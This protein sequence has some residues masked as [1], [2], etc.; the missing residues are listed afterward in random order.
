MS[1]G[2]GNGGPQFHGTWLG[3]RA[4]PLPGTPRTPQGRLFAP[5][6]K[7][8]GDPLKLHPSNWMQQPG[9]GEKSAHSDIITWHASDSTQLP[10]YDT[11]D[12][13]QIQPE[14]FEGPDWGNSEYDD[15]GEPNEDYT[16]FSVDDKDRPM[17]DYGSAIGMHF[18][19][20]RA[21]T[22]RAG[23]MGRTAFH[24]VRLP[25]ETVAPPPKGNFM[26]DRPGGSIAAGSMRS[27][28]RI[29][30]AETG[31]M[32]EDT[33]WSD[34]AANFA[35]KATDLVE[36][37]KSIA[38]RNDVE[39]KGTTSYRALPE[40]VRTWSEDVLGA[41]DPRSGMPATV[42][43]SRDEEHGFRNVPHPAL[44]HLAQAGYNPRQDTTDVTSHLG[45]EG[46]GSRSAAFDQGTLWSLKKP[47][48][49]DRW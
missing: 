48:E 40:T 5:V 38:Y 32:T 47:K 21:A 12:H 25:A 15:E 27:Q 44:V 22:E 3:D 26:Q 9:E 37:G 13:R 49:Q 2:N 6:G 16:D 36:S 35:S 34:P 1:E 46:Y 17:A 43:E 14:D 4:A 7:Y 33:R 20:V 30:N 19:D 28:V 23:S 31:E 8:T 18:G 11:P 42:G 10:R 39:G 45:E 24:P 29:K 41:T